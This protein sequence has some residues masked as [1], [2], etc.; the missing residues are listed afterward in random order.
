M[1]PSSFEFARKF[2]LMTTSSKIQAGSARRLRE[3]HGAFR[4]GIIGAGSTSPSHARALGQLPNVTL[5]GVLDARHERAAEL[6]GRFQIGRHFDD[7]DAF[8]A[9]AKPDVV[10]ILTPPDT[11]EALALEAL[12]RGCHVLVE[13]PPSL[14]LAGSDA[15][16]QAAREADL[17]VGL[18]ENFAM[19]PLIADARL[20]IARGALGRLVH[21][22]VFYA[23]NGTGIHADLSNWRWASS[24]PGGILEDLFPHPMTVARALGG[25]D[26]RPKHWEIFRSGRL[27]LELPD[28]L[29]LML[30]NQDGVTADVKL[31][32]SAHPPGFGIKVR[33]TA[34]T[35]EIDLS[36]MLVNLDRIGRGASAAAR[37]VSLCR[38][39]FGTLA[40]TT[41]NAVGTVLFRT[42]RPGDPIH[43]IVAHYRALQTGGELPA[44]ISRAKR[45]LEIARLI[46]P[47]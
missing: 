38:R 37:G 47:I 32:L 13:K 22:D 39:A 12:R 17:T 46:W 31:S 30:T 35:L 7:G 34:G 11:H 4:V 44:P 5:S 27:P 26:L 2:P 15:I 6:A 28:E 33:G 10:H 3:G 45:T 1:I 21:V 40:Q 25:E 42:P 9:E 29:R 19:H 20:Q 23:F 41:F 14:T 18:N 43:L 36:N 16:E 24:L 8:Y